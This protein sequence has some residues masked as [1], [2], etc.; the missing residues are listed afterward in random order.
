MALPRRTVCA[1]RVRPTSAGHLVERTVPVKMHSLVSRF[2][3]RCL[4]A[5][6]GGRPNTS[7]RRPRARLSVLPLEDRAIPAVTGLAAFSVGD[8]DQETAYDLATDSFGSSYIVG[9][10]RGVTD[11]DPGAGVYDVQGNP[12]GGTG[13]AAKYLNDGSLAW[14]WGFVGDAGGSA[15][16]AATDSAGNLYVA[17]GFFGSADFDPANTYADNRDLL[18]ANGS[19]PYLLKLNADGTFAW[20]RSLNLAANEFQTHVAADTLGNAYLATNNG[21]GQLV[22]YDAAG[23][24]LWLK[25]LNVT[26]QGVA[27]DGANVYATGGFTGSV[28][29]DPG[30]GVTTLKSGGRNNSSSSAYV[31]KLSSSNGSFVWAKNFSV[32]GSF[33]SVR[34]NDIAVDGLGNVYTTGEGS[35]YDVDYDPGKGSYKFSGHFLSKLN[36]SGNFVWARQLALDAVK[37]GHGTDLTLDGAGDVYVGGWVGTSD[38]SYGGGFIRKYSSTGNV[39][40]TTYAGS[41]VTGIAIDLDGNVLAC[42]WYDEGSNVFTDFTLPLPANGKADIFWMKLGQT[43]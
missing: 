1:P 18:T 15:N 3:R 41:R 23:N 25:Q 27:V 40:W 19:D 26:F 12:A 33:G 30:S 4:Q 2:S 31:L 9:Q 37:A 5:L 11:F 24:Q 10:H 20:V 22:K 16:S 17:G 42:G 7:E 14:A 38:G 34:G 43:A 39:V 21:P 28:D 36:S 29:F 35:S 32:T 6:G 13:Y 8:G